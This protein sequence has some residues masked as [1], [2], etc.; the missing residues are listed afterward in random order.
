MDRYSVYKIGKKVGVALGDDSCDNSASPEF[1]C[2]GRTTPSVGSKALF[3]IKCGAS[4]Y[5]GSDPYYF[6]PNGE[7]KQPYICTNDASARGD[8]KLFGFFPEDECNAIQD[9]HELDEDLCY[10]SESPITE[11]TASPTVSP[12][13]T[14]TGSPTVSQYAVISSI[15]F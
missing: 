13:A 4:T 11:P 9:G 8:W 14:L 5:I 7:K 15:Q 12:I 6:A 1:I 2:S 10:D 3:Q